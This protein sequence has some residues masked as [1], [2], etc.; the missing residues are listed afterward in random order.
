MCF[1][2]R[3]FFGSFVFVPIAKTGEIFVIIKLANNSVTILFFNVLILLK[4]LLAIYISV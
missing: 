2:Y 3:N 1:C 4:N